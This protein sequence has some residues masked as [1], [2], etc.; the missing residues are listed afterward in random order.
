MQLRDWILPS[1]PPRAQP[2]PP[3]IISI[4]LL[5][6]YSVLRTDVAANVRY[7]NQMC[8]YIYIYIYID[9]GRWPRAKNLGERDLS[10]LCLWLSRGHREKR[11]I[12]ILIVDW[13][14]IYR[15]DAIEE[16]GRREGWLRFRG[17][18]MQIYHVAWLGCKLTRQP[19]P[20]I[21]VHALKS[22]RRE[23]SSR[24]DEERARTRGRVP[25]AICICGNNEGEPRLWIVRLDLGS[26]SPTKGQFYHAKMRFEFEK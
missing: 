5:L 18:A 19:P 3:C 11:S 25:R 26:I 21:A 8:V 24:W 7:Y 16:G 9:V 22:A 6:H 1:R 15:Y 10:F 2:R 14:Y 13:L 17:T 4:R 20:V 12:S 23:Y